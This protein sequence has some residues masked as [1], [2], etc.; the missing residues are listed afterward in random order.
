MWLKRLRRASLALAAL[1]ALLLCGCDPYPED[2][3][4]TWVGL[5]ER[6]NVSMMYTYR[7]TQ[8]REEQFRLRVTQ[9]YYASENGLMLVWKSSKPRYFNAVYDS[10]NKGCLR[11]TFGFICY[12]IHDNVIKAG[13]MNLV[14]RAKNTTQKLKAAALN[15]AKRIYPNIPAVD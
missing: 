6:R 4:G 13:P 5:D 3:V 1:P 12:D 8:T 2:Y 14:R 9:S 15:S 7:I 10:S 11:G